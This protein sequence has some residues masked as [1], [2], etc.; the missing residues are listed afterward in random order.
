MQYAER[1]AAAAL[2]AD[3]LLQRCCETWHFGILKLRQLLGQ[4]ILKRFEV[5]FGNKRETQAA[6]PELLAFTTFPVT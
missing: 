2:S 6:R 3:Q 5:I 4:P 1:V